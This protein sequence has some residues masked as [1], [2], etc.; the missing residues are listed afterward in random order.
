MI[1]L[2]S[3]YALRA[4]LNALAP[5]IGAEAEA[6]GKALST[7]WSKNAD[8]EKVASWTKNGLELR[9]ELERITQEVT[10]VEYGKLMRKVGDHSLPLKMTS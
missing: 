7:G 3:I 8:K 5:L 10:S 9:S 4:L 6:G 1:L 2:S